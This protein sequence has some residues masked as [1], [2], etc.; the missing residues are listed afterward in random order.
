[1]KPLIAHDVVADKWCVVGTTETLTAD[2]LAEKYGIW[3]PIIYCQ[4]WHKGHVK[5]ANDV[6]H[7]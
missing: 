7:K 5:P 3:N 4:Q 2:Q 1:M 6:D